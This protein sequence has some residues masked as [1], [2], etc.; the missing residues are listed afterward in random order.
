MAGKKR[1]FTHTGETEGQP[2]ARSAKFEPIEIKSHRG[3][4]AH[5]RE[6]FQRLNSHPE[7]AKRL[8]LNPV[9]AFREVG[10]KTTPKISRHILR[11]I[12][13]TPRLRQRYNELQASLKEA[14]GRKP[15]PND[16]EWVSRFLFEELGLQPLD[17]TGHEPTYTPALN[18]PALERLQALRPKRRQRYG[19]ENFR[20]GKPSFLRVQFQSPA[21]RRFNLDASLPSLEPAAEAPPAVT[22]EEL[23]FYRDS[24][25]LARDLLELGMIERRSFR[26]QSSDSYRRIKDGRKANAFHTWVK[27]VRF[28]EE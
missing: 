14:A 18:T 26:I 15:W 9:L 20:P 8:L 25:P 24:H 11:T 28:P 12:Q 6:I 13:F 1:R 16:P 17:T 21:V 2:A 3:L 23:Y 7:L 10:V 4:I 5:Q 27:S 22:L 19:D